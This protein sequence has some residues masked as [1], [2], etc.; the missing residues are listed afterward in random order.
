M[1]VGFI[2]AKHDVAGA[3][4]HGAGTDDQTDRS[5][6]FHAA[7]QVDDGRVIAFAFDI[8]GGSGERRWTLVVVG[9]VR[10]FN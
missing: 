5:F 10:R 7:F 6:D 4:L 9:M 3:V 2:G 8:E 1:Q